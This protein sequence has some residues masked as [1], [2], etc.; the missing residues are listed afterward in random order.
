MRA[1]TR[2]VVRWVGHACVVA[3]AVGVFVPLLP[4]TPLLLLAAFCY[5]RSSERH[6]RW[7]IEN[8]LF[9]PVIRDYQQRRAVRLRVKVTALV[10][11]CASLSLSAW[12]ADHGVVRWGLIALGA[13]LSVLIL[14]LR[15]LR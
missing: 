4:T 10:L 12:L 11:L 9:G 15:T 6:Y 3:G 13:V 14:R 5:V 8:R 1:V 2:V 7:L